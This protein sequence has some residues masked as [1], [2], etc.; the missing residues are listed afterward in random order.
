MNLGD[1]ARNAVIGLIIVGIIFLL[2]G[3]IPSFSFIIKKELGI[4][5]GIAM[6]MCGIILFFLKDKDFS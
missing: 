4:I 1:I 2:L 3:F 5:I 6:I